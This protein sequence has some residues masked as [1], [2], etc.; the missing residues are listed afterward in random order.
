[1]LRGTLNSA[2]VTAVDPWIFFTSTCAAGVVWR[3]VLWHCWL[4]IRKSSRPRL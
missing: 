4:G 2:H 3:T 1:M